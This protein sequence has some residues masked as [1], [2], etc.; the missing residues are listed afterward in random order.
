MICWQILLTLTISSELKLF[1]DFDELIYILLR[2]PKVEN[3][4]DSLAFIVCSSGSTSAPKAVSKSHKQLTLHFTDR[5]FSVTHEQNICFN[6][7]TIYWIT[8]VIF[9]LVGSLYGSKRIIT[10]QNYTIEQ[11]NKIAKKFKVSSI[12]ASPAAFAEYV[13][14]TAISENDKILDSVLTFLSGG[15]HVSKHIIDSAQKYCP[16]AKLVVGFGE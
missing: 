15:S 8:G 10:T 4:A 3:I 12:F 1:L 13:A 14:A 5:Y 9:L 7:S 2:Y 6:F 11:F 16:N